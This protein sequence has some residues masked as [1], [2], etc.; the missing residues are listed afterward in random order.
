MG[1]RVA[2]VHE[3]TA[4]GRVILTG[5]LRRREFGGGEPHAET[6]HASRGRVDAACGGEPEAKGRRRARPNAGHNGGGTR[7]SHWRRSR[8]WILRGRGSGMRCSGGVHG[9]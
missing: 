3:R 6:A 4:G 9:R 2:G 7:R 8:A 1:G 5:R